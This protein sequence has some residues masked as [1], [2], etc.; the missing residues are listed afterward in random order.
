MVWWLR[1]WGTGIRK[2]SGKGHGVTE[3]N[4]EKERLEEKLRGDIQS[5]TYTGGNLRGIGIKEYA[6]TDV[7]TSTISCKT[8]IEFILKIQWAR[9]AIKPV[10]GVSGLKDLQIPPS[11]VWG[12][13]DQF[14]L[15]E[16]NFSNARHMLLFSHFQG[17]GNKVSGFYWEKSLNRLLPFTLDS[18][19]CKILFIKSTF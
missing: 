10:E 18:P 13:W 8:G 1:G 15:F 6:G 12:N 3:C 19:E 11:T 14:S 17:I 4:L 9:P 16:N 5:K 2:E 7:E